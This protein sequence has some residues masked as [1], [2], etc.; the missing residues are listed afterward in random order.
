MFESVLLHV[1]GAIFNQLLAQFQ[2]F[3]DQ[4]MELIPL[5]HLSIQLNIP[6][7]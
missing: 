4:G 5:E 1:V 7:I 3:F 2:K 6:Q